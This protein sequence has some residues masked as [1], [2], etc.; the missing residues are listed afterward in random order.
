MSYR[1]LQELVV[2]LWSHWN[3]TIGNRHRND[4]ADEPSPRHDGTHEFLHRFDTFR[5]VQNARLKHLPGICV[6]H[7][8]LQ[9][10]ESESAGAPWWLDFAMVCCS[11]AERG[12]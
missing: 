3:T 11:T 9:S 7:D 10:E 8:P 2:G 6:A 1:R 4:D 12:R 5:R